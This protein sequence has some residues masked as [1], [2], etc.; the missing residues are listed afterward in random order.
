M[1]LLGIFTTRANSFGAI[2]GAILGFVSAILLWHH[3]S[4]IWYALSTG[5]VPTLLFGYLFS[6][7]AVWYP[8]NDLALLTVWGR[9]AV[10]P[11]TEEAEEGE[12]I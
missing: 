1:F 7:I 9:E 8:R 5:C 3:V 11:S 4:F 6:V 2:L 10:L 12:S